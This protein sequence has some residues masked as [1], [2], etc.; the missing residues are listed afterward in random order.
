MSS[1]TENVFVLPS[2][3]GTDR[4]RE[5]NGIDV[6]AGDETHVT[7]MY[8]PPHMTYMYPPPHMTYDVDA[9]DGTHVDAGDGGS[10][11]YATRCS[12]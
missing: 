9:G 4:S 1:S 2:R 11:T 12:T 10:S 5:R 7:Y 6:D 3:S 8:P